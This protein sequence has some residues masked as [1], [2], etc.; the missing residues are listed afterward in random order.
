MSQP[1][2]AAP[3]YSTSP[4]APAWGM[5]EQPPASLLCAQSAVQPILIPAHLAS[6]WSMMPWEV[7]RMMWPNWREGSRRPTH[8]SMSLAAMS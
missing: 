8:A 2:S 5:T 3:C 4:A 1:P 6:S 7:V